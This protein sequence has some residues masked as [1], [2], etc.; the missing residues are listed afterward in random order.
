M[1][2]SETLTV[3]EVA[4]RLHMSE[5]TVKKWLRSGR[6]HGYRLGGDRLGWRVRLRDLEAFEEERV[7][8]R[9]TA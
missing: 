8:E 6:L 7:A 1:T 9:N 5:Y 3:A 4:A 2:T